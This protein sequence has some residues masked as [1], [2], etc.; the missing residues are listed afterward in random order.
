MTQYA[1]KIGRGRWLVILHFPADYPGAGTKTV[2]RRK[3]LV[4]SGLA[5]GVVAA[6]PAP[7]IAQG[8][9]ELKLVT[10]WSKGLLLGPAGSTVGMS[11]A[12]RSSPFLSLKKRK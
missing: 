3:F 2:D 12:K 6:F 10:G 11:A 8:V 1:A 5:A 4:R 7:A 9:R